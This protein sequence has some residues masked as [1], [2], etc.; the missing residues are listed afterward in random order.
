MN[1]LAE[2][3]NMLVGEPAA[4][5]KDEQGNSIQVF[6]SAGASSRC[7]ASRIVQSNEIELSGLARVSGYPSHALRWQ[8]QQCLT[9]CNATYEHLH[10][11]LLKL[12]S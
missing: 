10:L 1:W 7:A 5:N 6:A 12:Y 9:A 4:S 11:L 8:Q 3:G 2:V